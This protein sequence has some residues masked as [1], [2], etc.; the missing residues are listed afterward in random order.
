MQ[1]RRVK[2]VWRN[3][4]RRAEDEALGASA[5]ILGG[6]DEVL[7]VTRLGLPTELRR[8]LACPNIIENMMG[9]VRRV[10]LNVKRWRTASMALRWRPQ[11]RCSKQRRAFANSK[12][13]NNS[14]PFAWPS[15]FTTRNAGQTTA[16]LLSKARA[17]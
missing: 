9:T 1:P 15:K 16:L 14:Q 3:L 6:L 12:H 5:S 13:T 7:T 4:A 10:C 11:P 2:Q 17:A 8:A